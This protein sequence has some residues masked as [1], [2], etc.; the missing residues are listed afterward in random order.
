VSADSVARI[1]QSLST[2]REPALQKIMPKPLVEI[3]LLGTPVWSWL[4]MVVLGLLLALVSKWLSKLVVGIAKPIAKHYAPWLA[5]FRLAT[6]TDPIRL[7][8]S[9]A[10]FRA[11]VEAF[12]LSALV[13]QF[14]SN[15][16]ALLAVIGA[17]STL[18]RLTDAASD[19]IIARLEA[20]QRSLS[21]SVFPLGVRF[22]KV[23][24]FVA[25]VLFVLQKW[26]DLQFTTILAGVGVGGLAVALAAQK[27]LENLFGGI[28]I[29]TDRPVLVGDVCQFGGQTGTVADIG[30]RSTRVRTAERTVVTIPN[31][32]FSTMTLEN[33]SQRDRMLF[34]PVLQL[35]RDTSP[36]QIRELM[37][38]VEALLRTQPNVDPTDVPVRF[39]SIAP[40]SFRLEI[41]SYIL[42][43]D[44]NEFLRAQTEL[45]LRILEMTEELG[46]KLAVP[47][48]ESWPRTGQTPAS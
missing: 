20:R 28:S 21:Y 36:G 17:A 4:V 27:T 45:L 3:K 1:P 35:R 5:G 46:V 23:C 39:V 42:T 13:H 26:W 43:T 18:M 38:A 22:I 31:A 33:L 41:F 47:F 32:T 6:L 25:G 8:L 15:I 11:C 9:V 34:K 2:Y 14:V 24:I 16:L 7:L 44:G 37:Q 48:Q 10:V 19:Q 40:E 30:L 29:L 12:A